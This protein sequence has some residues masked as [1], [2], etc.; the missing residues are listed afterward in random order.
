MTTDQAAVRLTSRARLL[1]LVVVP[2]AYAGLLLFHPI[3]GGG[4]IDH[5]LAHDLATWNL[6]HVAQLGFIGAMGGAVLWL[7]QG[8]AGPAA[9]AAR[10]AAIVFVLVYG[11]YE[12][13]TGIVTGSLTAAAHDLPAGDQA[14]ASTLIQA[15]W[16][17]GLL[18]NGSIGAI[19]GSAA[20]LVA[21]TAAAFALRGRA[22][23]TGAVLTLIAS[24][25]VFA[26]THVPPAGPLAMALF[27]IAVIWWDRGRHSDLDRSRPEERRHAVA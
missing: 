3:P 8:I 14:A 19:T 22:A 1:Y 4:A 21:V 16:D 6:V 15:H 23:P 18:G 5:A 11:A 25:L 2:L 9:G 12:T 10:V 27:A 20:W 24:G 13:W 7:I 26:P 17:S